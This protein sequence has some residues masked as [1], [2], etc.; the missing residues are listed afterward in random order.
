MWG[1]IKPCVAVD[2][3]IIVATFITL[4]HYLYNTFYYRIKRCGRHPE[5]LYKS[6]VWCSH[7]PTASWA[8]FCMTRNGACWQVL[9][10]AQQHFNLVTAKSSSP[11][12]SKVCAAQ[13]SLHP[14]SW[15]RNIDS[16]KLNDLQN[17]EVTPSATLYFPQY[18]INYSTRILLNPK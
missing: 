13:S 9:L 3:L 18:K 8:L 7:L 5:I 11:N 12:P 6:H 16:M 4:I 2:L 14:N 15:W 10:K 1:H 17:S